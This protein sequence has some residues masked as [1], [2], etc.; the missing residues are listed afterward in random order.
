MVIIIIMLGLMLLTAV[1]YLFAIAPAKAPMTGLD[2]V[3]YAHRGLHNLEEGIPENSLAAFRLAAE[4]RYGIELDLRFSKDGK[5]VVFHDDALKRICG[6]SGDVIDYTYEELLAFPLSG[7]EQRIPLFTQVLQTID[8]SVPMII[9]IKTGGQNSELCRQ[10]YALLQSYKGSYCI[11]SYDPRIVAWFRK[12]APGVV[13]GIL[14][15]KADKSS[16]YSALTRFILRYML[17]NFVC[18]PNFLAYD[19]RFSDNL[20]L[21]LCKNLFHGCCVAWTVRSPEQADKTKFDLF[22]FE[23]FRL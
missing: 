5:I 3:H 17:V 15:T 7:T 16:G 19:C 4:N 6:V 23:N 14:A 11:E 1:L 22:I 10:I 18:R 9:E 8:G 2:G 21:T 12:N 20:S 13:R